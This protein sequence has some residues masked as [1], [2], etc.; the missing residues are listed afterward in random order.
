MSLEEGPNRRKNDFEGSE[1]KQREKKDSKE[2]PPELQEVP[3][4][5]DSIMSNSQVASK[6]IRV[7]AKSSHI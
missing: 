2:L 7:A 6:T 4:Q 1:T 3:K 5:A